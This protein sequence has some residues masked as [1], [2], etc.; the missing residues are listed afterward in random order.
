VFCLVQQHRPLPVDVLVNLHARRLSREV[1]DA[2]AAL[3]RL[4]LAREAS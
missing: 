1:E 3:R 4:L 2:L